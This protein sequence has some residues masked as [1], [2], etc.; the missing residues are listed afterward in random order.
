MVTSM[1]YNPIHSLEL[2]MSKFKYFSHIKYWDEIRNCKAKWNFEDFM[3]PHKPSE[4]PS[5]VAPAAVYRG[6]L[7]ARNELDPS[8]S[9]NLKKYR[10]HGMTWLEIST[11]RLPR[12]TPKDR[13][14]T[15]VVFLSCM[16]MIQNGDY[17]SFQKL[18]ELE[19]Q[20][21]VTQ[22]HLQQFRVLSQLLLISSS[23]E[24]PLDSV[25]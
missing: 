8:F 4:I 22:K 5:A 24:V 18:A 11:E 9:R 21:P 19:R 12:G 13:T 2:G 10:E 20:L 15:A 6:D 14:I 3:E 23:L 17:V 1:N 7:C 25:L 16:E